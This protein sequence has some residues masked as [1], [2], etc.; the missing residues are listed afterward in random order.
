MS[1]IVQGV[2]Y[3]M[4]NNSGR[5]RPLQPSYM[6]TFRGVAHMLDPDPVR[7]CVHRLYVRLGENRYLRMY[8]VY[9]GDVV[10]I[11]CIVCINI[12]CIVCIGETVVQ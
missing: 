11:V 12:V 10:G 1:Y 5:M 7:V 8:S 4:S 2:S 3:I 9:R 6:L